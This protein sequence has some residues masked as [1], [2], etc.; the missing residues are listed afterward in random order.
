[1]IMGVIPLLH[2]KGGSHRSRS[3][4]S[5]LIA[6]GH[7]G[8]PVS[9]SIKL[10]LGQYSSRVRLGLQFVMRIRILVFYIY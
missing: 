1:M 6:V 5:G 8:R 4:V 3:I 9:D 7:L 10:A 2:A